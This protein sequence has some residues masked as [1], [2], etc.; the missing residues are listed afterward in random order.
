MTGLDLLGVVLDQMFRVK[1]SSL[2]F[3]SMEPVKAATMLLNCFVAS[4]YGREGGDEGG[5]GHPLE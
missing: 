3:L 1:Q 5:T 4:G 2:R